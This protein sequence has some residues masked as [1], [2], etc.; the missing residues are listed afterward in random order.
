M[1][2]IV[3]RRTRELDSQAPLGNNELKL[4]DAQAKPFLITA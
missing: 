1:N 3:R 4:A 2:R